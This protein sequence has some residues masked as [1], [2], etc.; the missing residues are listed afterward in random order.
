MFDNNYSLHIGMTTIGAQG[1]YGFYLFQINIYYQ[2]QI[3]EKKFKFEPIWHINASTTQPHIK[4]KENTIFH[5]SSNQQGNLTL[6]LTLAIKGTSVNL[7]FTEMTKGWVG[8]TGLGM[9][10][11]PLP[12]ASVK[13][14]I[15]IDNKVICVEGTG[16]QEHG[17]DI[18]RLHRSWYWGKFITD[19][20]NIIFSKNM[21]NRW[22]EDVFLVVVNNGES[23][24][25]SLHRE[26]ISLEHLEYIFDHGHIIPVQSHFCAEQGNISIDVEINIEFMDFR[27]VIVMNY[28]RIHAHIEGTVTINGVVETVDDF[29]IMD[30]LYKP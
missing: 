28:W 6:N 9:W 12:K 20:F 29:Q 10:G 3:I 26:N 8:F 13:G 7:T 23:N 19:N 21:K 17:W 18:R 5:G 4:L 22:E 24:Y 11:C 30:M 1:K 2:G 15:T 14:T 27:T 25:T 16:Y